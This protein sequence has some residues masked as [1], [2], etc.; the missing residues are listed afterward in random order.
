MYKIETIFLFIFIFS[1]LAILRIA[2]RFVITL[3]QDNPE[4]MVL[5]DRVIIYLGLSV[6]YIITYLI[7]S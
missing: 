7:K 6:S 1:V 3:S 2:F 4:R 5:S